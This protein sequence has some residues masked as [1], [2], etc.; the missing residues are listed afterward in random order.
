MPFC[1]PKLWIPVENLKKWKIVLKCVI[2]SL[3]MFKGPFPDGD[4]AEDGYHGLAP[5]TAFPPQNNYGDSV[6]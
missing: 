5:A 2:F 3:S 4:T 1:I 6:L